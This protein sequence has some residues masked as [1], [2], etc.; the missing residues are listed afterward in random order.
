MLHFAQESRVFAHPRTLSRQA[1]QRL[2]KG[3]R[4]G[5][6]VLRP[7]GLGLRLGRPLRY[8]REVEC[9]NSGTT[10]LRAALE[11]RAAEWKAQLRAE[12]HIARLVLRRVVGPI[13]LHDDGERPE[14]VTWET[15]PT[16][17][18]LDGLATLRTRLGSSPPGFEPGFQP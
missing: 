2:R 10:K 16:T 11:Q 12:P 18:L 17:D 3:P 5:G 8:V 4:L 6:G 15:E 7:C 9:R 1:P 14:F 13:V